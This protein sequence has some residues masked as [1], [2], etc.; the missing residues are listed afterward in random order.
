MQ[1]SPEKTRSLLHELADW[2]L[3]EGCEPLELVVCGGTALLLQG[4]ALRTTR[5]VDVLGQWTPTLMQATCIEAFPE[6]V[7]LCIA[8][9]AENHPELEGMKEDW[10]N[11]G[12]RRL[13]RWGLPAGYEQRL[14]TVRFND[15]LTLKLLS[16]LDLMPLKLYAA[17]DDLGLRQQIHLAD[18]KAL[19]PT[20]EELDVA[21]DLVR[22]LP[23][24]DEKRVQLEAIV[25]E[26]GYDDLAIYI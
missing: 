21:L 18:L 2:L 16:R 24:I 26:L 25:E 17:A 9:V 6:K 23:G 10:V 3:F 4:L 11:L 19:K 22:K 8:R 12:P 5:D 13:A 15:R 1:L 7:R 20:F 14:T